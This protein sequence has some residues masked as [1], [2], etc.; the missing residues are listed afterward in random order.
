M[1]KGGTEG[2]RASCDSEYQ[3]T[4][5]AILLFPYDPAVKLS[6]FRPLAPWSVDF[7]KPPYHTITTVSS[8]SANAGG[9]D[10]AMAH[11]ENWPRNGLKKKP[12]KNGYKVLI[13][14]PHSTDFN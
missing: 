11:Y 4:C 1:V 2:S 9:L 8:S 13:Q 6:S 3:M 14:P 7:T 5:I 12:H 10:D